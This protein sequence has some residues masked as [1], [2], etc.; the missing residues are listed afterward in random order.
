MF[1]Q[2]EVTRILKTALERK[3]WSQA[4]L[5]RELNLA[6]GTASKWVNGKTRPRSQRDIQRLA[7]ALDIEFDRLARAYTRPAL[8]HPADDLRHAYPGERFVPAG[9]SGPAGA[10]YTN[11]A[12][13][14]GPDVI[15]RDDCRCIADRGRY[16]LP[17]VIRDY[18]HHL[19]YPR[20]RKYE[21][22]KARLVEA[23]WDAGGR[24]LTLRFQRTTYSNY[25]LT[26][27]Q[28]LE[29]ASVPYGGGET[30][31]RDLLEPPGG[32]LAPLDH[33][34]C[35][36]HLGLN[37]LL[38]DGRGQLI[39]SRRATDLVYLPQAEA[40]LAAAGSMDWSDADPFVAMMR[41]VNE[42]LLVMDEEIEAPGLLLMGIARNAARGGKPE[43]F[44]VGFTRLSIDEI[45]GRLTREVTNDPRPVSAGLPPQDAETIRVD[46]YPATP[47]ALRSIV[48]T[49]S[50][51]PETAVGLWF[52]G[53]V[54]DQVERLRARSSKRSR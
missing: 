33:S 2:D 20:G 48:E 10:R 35:S 23:A 13:T 9:S 40:G 14:W 12:L 37:A 45:N 41:E 34:A 36:N 21:R 19:N 22:E 28:I 54:R 16:A 4:Q 1:K 38:L 53:E 3:Q 8:V 5:A 31:L 32:S 47:R 42:E 49:I 51:T 15:A 30:L 46:G 52:Y 50:A 17:Q 27:H 11:F 44:F 26:N 29:G 7:K 6:E 18:R 24:R 25:L 39:L 43:A